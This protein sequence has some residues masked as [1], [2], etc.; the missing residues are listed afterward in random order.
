MFSKTKSKTALFAAA[1]FVLVG[2]TVF[3]FS[4]I[5][6]TQGTEERILI[7]TSHGAISESDKKEMARK[8]MEERMQESIN[9]MEGIESSKVMLDD[10]CAVVELVLSSET[11]FTE[12]MENDIKDYIQRTSSVEETEII[13]S[14]S[15]RTK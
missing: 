15:V 6:R 4:G 12:D 1:V 11:E 3:V 9:L 2:V 10:E 8:T 14:G 13:V 5:T 7:S